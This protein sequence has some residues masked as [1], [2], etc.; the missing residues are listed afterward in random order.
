MPNNILGTEDTAVI[1]GRK[2]QTINKKNS[3]TLSLMIRRTI[4]KNKAG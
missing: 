1:S 2:K 4:E 3:N